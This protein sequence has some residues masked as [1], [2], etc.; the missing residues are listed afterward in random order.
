MADTT[1]HHKIQRMAT[2]QIS[3]VNHSI[4]SPVGL[5]P[6]LPI[7]DMLRIVSATQLTPCWWNAF[8]FWHSSLTFLLFWS[9]KVTPTFVVP[10]EFRQAPHQHIPIGNKV[11]LALA[12]RKKLFRLKFNCF[13]QKLL[14]FVSD[15]ISAFTISFVVLLRVSEGPHRL[16]FIDNKD[17]LLL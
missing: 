2:N 5:I 4:S 9:S 17:R 1:R 8:H 3:F 13:D 15:I 14:L 6:L 16:I 12:T 7:K 10:Y 11:R